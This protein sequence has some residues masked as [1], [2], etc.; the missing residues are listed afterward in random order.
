MHSSVIGNIRSNLNPSLSP[1][2]F[3]WLLWPTFV[4][5]WAAAAEG[6][7]RHARFRMLQHKSM[8]QEKRRAV[9]GVNEGDAAAEWF[10]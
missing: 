8:A 9:R 6:P 3:N 10:T 5:G 4:I 7:K 1:Y 2:F